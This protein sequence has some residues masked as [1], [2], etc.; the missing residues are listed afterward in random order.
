MRIRFLYVSVLLTALISS[1]AASGQSQPPVPKDTVIG[2][3]EYFED[4]LSRIISPQASIE[5]IGSGYKWSEGP[6]WVP[7]GQYL[8]FS[9]VPQNIIYKWDGK[10]RPEKWLSPS[11]YTGSAPQK[12]EIGSNGLSLDRN[13][14][15]IICQSGDRKVA[16]LRTAAGAGVPDTPAP[17]YIFFAE[18]YKGKRFNSPN[19]LTTNSKNN[20]YFTDPIYGLPDGENDPTRELPFEGVYRIGTDGMTTL[21]LDSIR[22]PNGIAFSPDEKILYIASS[23]DKIPRWY[24]YDLDKDGKIIRGGLF[25]DAAPLRDRAM[26]KQGPDGMKIDKWGNLFAAGPD[27]INIIS[28][29]ARRIALIRI[30]GRR[31]SNCAFNETKEIL[32]ITADDLVLKVTLHPK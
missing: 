3:I 28:P 18:N 8:L 24:A 15:L 11:G 20:V 30:F 13:G 29:Q 6:V 16:R 25:L 1:G 5:V 2:K 9:D 10:K 17:E 12:G 23:D 19:D 22:R 7:A 26:V 14:Q 21:L 4:D 27:G 31:V 32:F